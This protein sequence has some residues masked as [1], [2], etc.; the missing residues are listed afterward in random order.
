MRS[1]L[2]IFTPTKRET[3]LARQSRRSLAEA[4]RKSRSAE[5]VRLASNG[6][7]EEAVEV[8]ASALR[9]LVSILNEMAEGRSVAI[10]P[11]EAEITTQE[12]ADLLNVSRP[13]LVGLLEAGEIPFRKVGSRRRVR[14]KDVLAYKRRT[15]KR[16]AATLDELVREAQRLG[17]GY[18]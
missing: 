14:L 5:S 11:F 10:A 17:L 8:P 15:D 4:L 16:R 18:R 3:E 1:N 13:F 12:A 2:K 6:G 7:E 9:L